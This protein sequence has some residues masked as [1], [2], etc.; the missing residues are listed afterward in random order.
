MTY[1]RKLVEVALPLDAIS[2]ASAREKT[3]PHG[4]PSTLHQW[5]ARRPMAAC[6]AALWASLVDDPSARPDRFPSDEAQAAERRRLF[7]ILE[8][9]VVMKNS[10]NPDVLAEARAEIEASCE[11][12]RPSV[13]DPFCGGGTIPLEAQRLGMPS[14]GGDLNPVAVLIS[15][16]MVEIPPR[17]AGLPPINPDVR[18]ESGLKT[19]ERAQGLAEDVG[20]YGQWIRDRAFER[21]GHLYPTARLPRSEG[22]DEVNVIAWIWARTVRS[23]D[24]SW[25]GD[26]PLV[27]SWILRKAKK[28]RPVVWV[29]PVVDRISQTTSYRIRRG[30]DD[31]VPKGTITRWAG[32]CVATGTP[33][34]R[35]YLRR[36]AMAGRLGVHL[37]AIVAEGH[38]RRAYLEPIA[39]GHV[40]RPD[41]V[42]SARL[43]SNTR[44]MSPPVYGLTT[45]D[46]L[47]TDRQLV[48]LSEF[49]SLLEKLRPVVE[50]H[51]RAAGLSDD[52]VLLRNGGSGVS[53]Y[54]DAIATYLAF[55]VDRCADLWASL[56]TWNSTGQTL[57][58]VFGRQAIP[59]MWDYAE[60]NPFSGSSGSWSG[61][62]KWI[63]K[64]VASLPAEGFGLVRQR[65]AVLSLGEVRSPLICT[66][67]PY[68]DN[69]PYAD[70]S[71]F[72]YVWLRHNLSDIWPE[73]TATLLT[74][75]ADELVADP[76]RFRQK[77]PDDPTS[78]KELAKRH[79]EKGMAKVLNQIRASQ[80]SLFPA[81][82]F[83]AFK[84]QE[85]KRGRAASAST[86]WETF[87]QGL[88]DAG[89]QITATW[90]IRTEMPSR[91]RA[92]ASAA[93]ASSVV[94][95]CRPRPADA[96][97]ATRRE[98]LDALQTE[99]PRAVRLLQ[100][101]AIAPV[102]MAQSAIGPGM[103]IF[104]RYAKVLEADGTP[105]RVRTAL[106]LINEAL[107]LAL[108]Q[109]ETEFDADTRW[110]LTWYE[111]FGHDRG[112][113]GDAETLAKAKNTSV[114]G[115]VRAGVAES[116]A[117]K[118]C[119]V[120]REE[121]LEEWDPARDSRL[122]VWKVTQQLV[123][124]LDHSE[125]DA[126][127]LLCKVGGGIG[128]RA[129]RLAY[130]LYQIAD[131]KGW[132]EDAVAYNRL[133]RTWHDI[134]R[135]AA[136]RLGP[137]A[138]TL[139]GI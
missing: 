77:Q 82:I 38:R 92:M 55:V 123:A 51:A 74:P 40:V 128:D 45:T 46:S 32:T 68:Y 131:R 130:L 87:L 23:P 114:E 111:Q 21:I 97:L 136:A 138:Q 48:A 26:V 133:V 121:P 4:H 64:A 91:M 36:N 119:L 107:E 117:G 99:L 98:L 66:D 17:F 69:V 11:G 2:R 47:F 22:G 29:E 10:N 115:V 16:A 34:S 106:G 95:A 134:A 61:Q 75:K 65:D 139:E 90:P 31:A 86:G 20:F 13:L 101:Q 126:A 67:P 27:R 12:E 93:L 116:R 37:I 124:R 83:Y 63:Q 81:T 39:V 53:A 109:E 44:H 104:S 122:T 72:F 103:E 9:L 15:K 120:A 56:V 132:S 19:W 110:A 94:I 58:H 60:A 113:F 135:L 54:A 6:R 5:W 24:P 76:Q 137:V 70:L 3:S 129:R 96:L 57:Q 71:D 102:D 108:S 41:R 49:S 125:T 88:V 89:L 28:N 73:E 62:M 8:Q 7:G 79:F 100:D 118:V 35:Q 84:Q 18:A 80:H 105:M 127:D 42:A 59:M 50:G 30:D 14:Y 1:K 52:G 78:P 25:D 33:I 85:T 43:S 112:Q